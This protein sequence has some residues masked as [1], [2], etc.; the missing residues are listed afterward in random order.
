M[1]KLKSFEIN[2][3]KYSVK[4]NFQH[5]SGFTRGTQAV[6]LSHVH[7]LLLLHVLMIPLLLDHN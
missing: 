2:A 7:V 3:L 6:V 1:K 4:Q 5:F